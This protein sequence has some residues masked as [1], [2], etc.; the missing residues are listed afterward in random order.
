LHTGQRIDAVLGS[1]VFEHLFRLPPLYFQHRP[2]G[3]IA[4]RLAACKMA[5]IHHVIEALPNGYQDEIGER[6]AG[7]SGGQRQ[8]LS[9]ARALLKRPKVLI[10]D[11]ATSSVDAATAEQLGRTISTLKGRVSILFI[12]HAL[13][14]S[15]HAD[16]IVRIGEKLTVVAGDKLEPAVQT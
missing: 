16:H 15:L 1:H 6:G 5:E 14:R 3:V 13:P 10:F 12:A 4:A 2:T 8:R 9:I 7:L 11:E